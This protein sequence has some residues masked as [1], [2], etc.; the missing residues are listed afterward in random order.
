[1]RAI[2]RINLFPGAGEWVP[3]LHGSYSFLNFFD[4][5]SVWFPTSDWEMV[6]NNNYLGITEP[7]PTLSGGTYR[8]P[9]D[10]VIQSFNIDGITYDASNNW[11][12]D[13]KGRFK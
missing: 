12:G 11:Q 13:K 7:S 2:D 8:P 6:C 10:G 3:D 5:Q 1:M 4:K 9:Y